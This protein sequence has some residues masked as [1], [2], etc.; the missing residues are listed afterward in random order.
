MY[1]VKIDKVQKEIKKIKGVKKCVSNRLSIKDFR[2]CLLK[3][4]LYYDSMY[5]LR[6]K[7]HQ[8]Y[9]QHISKLTLSYLDDKR[10]IRVNDIDTYAWGHYRIKNTPSSTSSAPS[11]TSSNKNILY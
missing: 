7:V 5:V 9:T 4:Q 6:S 11:S 2:K 8:I 3:K 1:S 10:F